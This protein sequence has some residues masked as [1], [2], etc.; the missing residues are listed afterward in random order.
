MCLCGFISMSTGID[1]NEIIEYLKKISCRAISSPKDLRIIS[2]LPKIQ[3]NKID[4]KKLKQVIN[5]KIK[6]DV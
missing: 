1:L 2:E 4:I 6:T 3:G 5:E